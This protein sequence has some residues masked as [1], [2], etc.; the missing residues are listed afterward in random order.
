MAGDWIKMRPE[1]LREPEVIGISH[2]L[3]VTRQHVIGCLL[4]VW[5][6]GDQ[7]AV[8]R[9]CP[10]GTGTIE[11][12]LSRYG[13]DDIDREAG[14]VGFAAAMEAEG[15]LIQREDGISFPEW[16]AHNSRSA[17]TRACESK[18][19]QKQRA[20]EPKLSTKVSQVCPD[21]TGTKQGTREEK[22]RVE[23]LEIKETSHAP[24]Q[25]ERPDEQ[26]LR[27]QAIATVSGWPMPL[28]CEPST[29]RPL[30]ARWV[31]ARYTEWGTWLDAIRWD[32][33]MQRYQYYTQEQWVEALT[34]SAQGG[35]K[36]LAEYANGKS[37]LSQG[38]VPRSTAKELQTP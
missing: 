7:H 13:L 27:S 17:K 19:K 29:I 11:G 12:H 10:D 3:G 28:R 15:W 38:P 23:V 34:A 8:S 33:T 16:D 14:H 18:K 26:A 31:Y 1:L 21:D 22:R 36:N 20:G 4:G 5:G 24:S 35:N 9:I 2:R 37:V 32:A 6:V 30:V 25:A